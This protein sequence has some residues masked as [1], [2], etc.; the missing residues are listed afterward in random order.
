MES[1][2]DIFTS[3]LLA[4]AAG[5]SAILFLRGLYVSFRRSSASFSKHIGDRLLFKSALVF[6]FSA[7]AFT[8]AY[9]TRAEKRKSGNGEQGTGNGE[10]GTAYWGNG[11]P[12]RLERGAGNGIQITSFVAST[13]SVDI[14]A[15]LYP[16]CIIPGARILAY[17]KFADLITNAWT[18]VS[19][20]IVPPVSA[21]MNPRSAMRRMA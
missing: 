5:L 4:A 13:N 17:A 21:E 8:G 16:E 3:L 14:E 12:A 15:T 9:M 11:R 18:N 1:F 2:N 10:W 19:S 20:S 7:I 6:L